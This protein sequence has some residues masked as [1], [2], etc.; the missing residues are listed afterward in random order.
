MTSLQQYLENLGRLLNKL[1][2]DMPP[3]VTQLYNHELKGF[4]QTI[5]GQISNI[6]KALEEERAGETNQIN[7]TLKDIVQQ[8]ITRLE[9][10]RSEQLVDLIQA[11]RQQ[12]LQ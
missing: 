8:L 3:E 12:Y 1:P 5:Q 9:N 11:L 4:L 2:A 10:L 6:K 7:D